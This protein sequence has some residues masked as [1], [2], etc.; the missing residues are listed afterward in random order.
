MRDLDLTN[1]TQSFDTPAAEQPFRDLRTRSMQQGPESIGSTVPRLALVRT[2]HTVSP[3][4]Q[5]LPSGGLAAWQVR[6]VL[7][8][9]HAGLAEEIALS[10]LAHIARLSAFHFVRAFK[11]SLGVTPHRYQIRLRV[12]RACELLQDVDVPVT[13][14]AF[15]VGYQSSQSFARVFRQQMGM[16]PNDYRRRWVM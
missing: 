13:E 4:P 2:A 16:S 11:R 15:I 12:Q 9:L 10:E 14:I 7:E 8:R 6:R 3:V 1:E 5:A